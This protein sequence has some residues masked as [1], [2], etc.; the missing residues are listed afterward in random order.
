MIVRAEVKVR[1]GLAPIAACGVGRS[2]SLQCASPEA[3][4]VA[5][6]H[7]EHAACLR[8]SRWGSEVRANPEG[9]RVA[10]LF[11]RPIS[12]PEVSLQHTSWSQPIFCVPKA[13]N[14]PP[15][16]P[17]GSPT[18]GQNGKFCE[19]ERPSALRGAGRVVSMV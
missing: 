4:Y 15:S 5:L 2:T 16:R 10:S 1:R 14:R 11:D 19:S 7:L 3:C 13:P 8:R 9:L 17:L 12:S 18:R 6:E